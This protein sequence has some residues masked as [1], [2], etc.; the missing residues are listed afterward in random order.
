MVA[1]EAA[2]PGVWFE[3]ADAVIGIDKFGTSGNGDDVYREYGFDVDKI[4]REIKRY[5][6]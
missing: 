3:I 2:A 4:I 5:I 1:I 6:K